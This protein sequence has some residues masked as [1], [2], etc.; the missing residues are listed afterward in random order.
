MTK[1]LAVAFMWSAI[2]GLFLMAGCSS[3]NDLIETT[4]DL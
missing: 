4:S 2:A 3:D 1:T